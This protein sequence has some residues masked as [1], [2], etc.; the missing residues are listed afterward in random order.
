M[1]ATNSLGDGSLPPY[2]VVDRIDELAEVIAT[3]IARFAFVAS[4]V[5]SDQEMVGSTT[6]SDVSDSTSGRVRGC[7]DVDRER[8][9]RCGPRG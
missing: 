8:G 9:R 6:Y 3:E 5:L 1:N 2:Q 7:E 4:A